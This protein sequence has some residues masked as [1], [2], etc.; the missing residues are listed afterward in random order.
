MQ[1]NRLAL[2]LLGVPRHLQ[3]HSF[4][5]PPMEVPTGCRYIH[6]PEGSLT[7][8]NFKTARQVLSKV[9]RLEADGH[10]GEQPMPEQ[11]GTRQE[12]TCSR[13]APK[14]DGTIPLH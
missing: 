12:C 9:I 14:Q 1:L 7:L 13:Q 10:Y 3:Q 2:I 6:K 11:H 4:T 8:L 5:G